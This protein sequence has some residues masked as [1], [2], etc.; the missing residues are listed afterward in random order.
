MPFDAKAGL[1][2][3][4]AH[5]WATGGIV[6]AVGAVFLLVM[7]GNKGSGGSA[8]LAAY[9]QAETAQNAQDNAAGIAKYQTDAQ[10][11]Q[12][13]IAADS[14][15]ALNKLWS[16][17][18]LATTNANNAATEKNSLI[19]YLGQ[20]AN[21]LG[22]VLT[23]TSSKSSGSGGGLNIGGGGWGFGFNS[24]SN[25]ATSSSKQTLVANQNQVSAQHDLD[26]IVSD[27]FHP[28]H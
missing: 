19:Q 14:T 6:F 12:S 8:N 3:V 1:T 16:E 4:K 11:R 9:L 23:S 24:N 10:T 27:L 22:T 17:N 7:G 13:Q 15:L 26:L 25:S 2:W 20:I 21:N 5:P 28:G 18:S